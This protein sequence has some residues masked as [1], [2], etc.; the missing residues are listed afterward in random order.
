MFSELNQKVAKD[1]RKK[2]W[3]NWA[4]IDFKFEASLGYMASSRCTQ[5]TQKSQY[6]KKR[7]FCSY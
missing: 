2:K 7:K 3:K 4:C 6:Q 5:A 1:T